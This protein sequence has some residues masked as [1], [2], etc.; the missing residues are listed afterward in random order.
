M[1][2]LVEEL[3]FKIKR[4]HGIAVS[5]LEMNLLLIRTIQYHH[6]YIME[7]I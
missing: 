6:Y 3:I 1:E 2:Y 5:K 7:L 4:Q